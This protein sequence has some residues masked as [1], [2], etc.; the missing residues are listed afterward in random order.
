MAGKA[1]EVRDG[2]GGKSA[3]IAGTRVRVSD[4]A[5]LYSLMEAELVAE[6]VQRSLPHL[7]L[8]QIRA[9]VTYWREHPKEVNEEISLEQSILE[10]LSSKP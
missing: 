9:A 6:R 2:A 1:I 10:K 4:I 5:R 3:Y 7:S 8:P